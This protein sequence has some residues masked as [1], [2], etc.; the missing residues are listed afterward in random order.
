MYLFIYV[1]ILFELC[2]RR[3][4]FHFYNFVSDSIYLIFYSLN[5]RLCHLWSIICPKKQRAPLIHSLFF[6]HWGTWKFWLIRLV[7][8]RILSNLA[9]RLTSVGCCSGNSFFSET[10]SYVRDI[11]RSA[12]HEALSW[13]TLYKVKLLHSSHQ[14]FD[15]NQKQAKS[16]QFVGSVLNF[17]SS[18]QCGH[19]AT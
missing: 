15:W 17:F 13:G 18:Q 7:Y 19:N 6:I 2:I 8:R 11:Y 10:W 16:W 14:D 1:L 3:I 5:L 4:H 12:K 9:E